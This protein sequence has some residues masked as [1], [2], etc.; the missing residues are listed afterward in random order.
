[1]LISVKEICFVNKKIL[2]HVLSDIVSVRVEPNFLGLKTSL[3]SVETF[4]KKINISKNIQYEIAH[5]YVSYTIVQLVR[6]GSR[7]NI[8]THQMTKNLISSIINDKTL[9][10]SLNYYVPLRGDSKIIPFLLKLKVVAVV[11]L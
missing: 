4:L 11:F 6:L 9:Q 3:K 2:N 5:T 7:H 8:K 1:M 10:N